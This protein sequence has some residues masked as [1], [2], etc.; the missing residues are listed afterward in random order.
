LLG[1]AEHGGA[2][3]AIESGFIAQDIARAAYTYQQEVD[4]GNRPVVGVSIFPGK[5]EEMVEVFTIPNEFQHE[6]L[7]RL[8]EVKRRRDESSVSKALRGVTAAASLEENTIPSLVEA[9]R[10]RA[11]LGEMVGALAEVFGR[12]SPVQVRL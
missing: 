4:L 3:A 9:A 2:V 12:Y 10:A 8:A 5:A 7:E 6:Q 11:T 1:L